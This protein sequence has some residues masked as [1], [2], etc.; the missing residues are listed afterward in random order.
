LLKI[1]FWREKGKKQIDFNGCSAQEPMHLKKQKKKK[2]VRRRNKKF[3]NDEICFV[4]S[5]SH[6][7]PAE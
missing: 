2:S 3:T 1:K 6:L 5:S 4:S 7:L